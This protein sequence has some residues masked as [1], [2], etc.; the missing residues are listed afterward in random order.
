MVTH[1]NNQED[2]PL[3][4]PI[5]RD[6]T[7]RSTMGKTTTETSPNEYNPSHPT[8]FKADLTPRPPMGACR[9]RLKQANPRYHRGPATSSQPPE[10]SS[11]VT[12]LRQVVADEATTTTTRTRLTPVH[13]EKRPGLGARTGGINDITSLSNIS[14]GQTTEKVKSFASVVPSVPSTRLQQWKGQ[15]EETPDIQRTEPTLYIGYGQLPWGYMALAEPLRPLGWRGPRPNYLANFKRNSLQG[16]HRPYASSVD[17]PTHQKM[18]NVP[19]WS[20]PERSGTSKK[21][22]KKPRHSI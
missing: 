22:H 6:P 13:S 16:S 5:T 11:M 14:K 19:D 9:T 15:E 1:L 10:S 21:H 2:S 17:V 7:H 4:N 8:A 12:S 18:P 20:Y 3:S